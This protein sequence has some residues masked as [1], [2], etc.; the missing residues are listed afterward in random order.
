LQPVNYLF[1]LLLGFLILD[2]F[3]FLGYRKVITNDFETFMKY[4]YFFIYYLT[5]F[6]II[7]I[8]YVIRLIKPFQY[9]KSLNK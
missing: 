9:F 2:F 7:Y 6:R 3:W 4:H 8:F 5:I 1:Y